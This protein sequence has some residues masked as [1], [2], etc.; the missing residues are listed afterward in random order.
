MSE[1]HLES[2]FLP[3]Q[4]STILTRLHS[5]CSSLVLLV[6]F[7]TERE[8]QQRPLWSEC[9]QA[10]GLNDTYWYCS[11]PDLTWYPTQ[12]DTE[13]S[14]KT[15]R[16]LENYLFEGTL[17]IDNNSSGCLPPLFNILVSHLRR[18]LRC[19]WPHT[20]RIMAADNQPANEW[21]RPN[22]QAR[23]LYAWLFDLVKKGK[24]KQQW[25]DHSTYWIFFFF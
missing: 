3:N 8:K 23:W 1:F 24:K 2:E 5:S 11:L 10:T 25:M 7:G 19:M 12:T 9:C 15:K 16:K 4:E 17:S 21:L 6:W 22:L 20:D 14:K 13:F 18:H